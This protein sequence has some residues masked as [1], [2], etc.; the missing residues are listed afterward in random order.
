MMI[1]ANSAG[2]WLMI[3]QL[4]GNIVTAGWANL[5]PRVME[6]FKPLMEMEVFQTAFK[7]VEQ[8]AATQ[9]WAAIGKDLEGKGGLY[10]DDSSIS[11][12]LPDDAQVGVAGYRPWAFNEAGAKQLWADSLEMVGEKEA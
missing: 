5:D 12:L 8:G 4:Q 9:V 6:K 1:T 3:H 2:S 7:S 11:F 10:L